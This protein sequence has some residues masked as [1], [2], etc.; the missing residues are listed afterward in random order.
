MPRR[1]S[2][3]TPGEPVRVAFTKWGGRPHWEYD[4]RLL[5]TDE[6]GT[7]VGARAGTRLRRPGVA[8]DAPQH[9]VTLIP[10]TGGFVATFYDEALHAPVTEGGWGMVEVYVD[11]TTPPVWDGSTVR[12]V[13]L[14]LDVVRSRVGRTW[15]DDEDE[16]AEH[17]HRYG[18]PNDVVRAA[19][20][21][22]DAVQ[23]AVAAWRG[24]YDGRCA[25]AWI[26]RLCD[27]PV[28]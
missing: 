18:Y 2:L 24:P 19:S 21:S 27:Q 3:T 7:W 22:C 6:H 13:D 26:S 10:D 17:R 14:D 4:A 28:A 15:V 12:A 11:I 20:A 16:F 1:D 9:F 23:S 5:G 25:P 8:I